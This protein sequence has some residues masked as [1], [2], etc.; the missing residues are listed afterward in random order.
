MSENLPDT[1]QNTALRDK[2]VSVVG[3]VFEGGDEDNILTLLTSLAN[4]CRNDAGLLVRPLEDEITRKDAAITDTV[5]RDKASEFTCWLLAEL[6]TVHGSPLVCE[7][8]V[9][10]QATIMRLLDSRN[11]RLFSLV[12]KDYVGI[13]LEGKEVLFDGGSVTCRSF[14]SVVR[15]DDAQLKPKDIQFTDNPQLDNLFSNITLVLGQLGDLVCHLG[16]L[17]DDIWLLV[18][19][20][21]EGGDTNLK[22]SALT[23]ISQLLDTCGLPDSVERVDYLLQCVGAMVLLPVKSVQDPCDAL[24]PAVASTSMAKQQAD[25]TCAATSEDG[26]TFEVPLAKIMMDL[27]EHI[28]HLVP[29]LQEEFLIML[30]KV[31]KPAT[32][33]EKIPE[34]LRKPLVECFCLLMDSLTAVSSQHSQASCVLEECVSHSLLVPEVSRVFL[35]RLVLAELLEALPATAATTTNSESLEPITKKGK[36]SD[37]KPATPP[38]TV[39]NISKWWKMAMQKLSTMFGSWSESPG[40]SIQEIEFVNI[41]ISNT[42]WLSVNIPPSE[43]SL[44]FLPEAW[45]VAMTDTMTT[46]ITSTE[47]TTKVVAM[48]NLLVTVAWASCI[49]ETSEVRATLLH[50]WLALATLPWMTAEVTWMDLKPVNARNLAQCAAKLHWTS[51]PSVK[52][53]SVALVALLP[54]FVAPCWRCH[55]V[56]SVISEQ[57]PQVMV[58]VAAWFPMMVHQLNE[59]NGQQLVGEVTGAVLLSSDTATVLAAAHCFRPLLCALLKLTSVKSLREAED[60]KRPYL[61]CQVCDNAAPSQCPS[62]TG[63]DT[64]LVSRFLGLLGHH[65]TAVVVAVVEALPTVVMHTTITS[66]MVSQ[67]LALLTHQD[68]AVVSVLCQQLP[69]LVCVREQ[70]PNQESKSLGMARDGEMVLSHLNGIVRES[71]CGEAASTQPVMAVLEALKHIV[72]HPLGSLTSGVLVLLLRCLFLKVRTATSFAHLAIH[73]L[74]K[75]MNLSLKDLYAR[76]RQALSQV[77][78]SAVNQGEVAAL[79][80]HVAE[81]FKWPELSVVSKRSPLNARLG[82]FVSSQLQYLLPALVVRAAKEAKPGLLQDLAGC[83]G[84]RLRDILIDHFQHILAHLVFH[85]SEEQQEAVLNF[86]ATTTEIQILDIRRCSVQNQVNE[87]VLGLHDHRKSVLREFHHMKAIDATTSFTSSVSSRASSSRSLKRKSTSESSHVPQQDEICE[88]LAPRLLGILGFLDNKLLSSSTMF[89]LDECTLEGLVEEVVIVVMPLIQKRPEQMEPVLTHVLVEMP[90]VKPLLGNLPLLPAV[91]ALAGI[92]KSIMESQPKVEGGSSEEVLQHLSGILKGLSHESIDVRLSA[93][94]RLRHA[95]HRNQTAVH[96]LTT[97]SDNVHPTVSEL[98]SALLDQCREVDED[99]QVLVAEC[100]GLLGAIDPSRLYSYSNIKEEL[101]EIHLNIESESF[102]VQLITELG[103]A[104]LA[105]TDASAQ[106]CASYALQEVTRLYGIRESG[107]EETT[108]VGSKAWEQLR[109]HLQE[110][111]HPLLTSKYTLSTGSGRPTPALSSPIFGSPHATSFQQ[112]LTSWECSLIDMLKSERATQVFNVCKPILRRDITTAM[113]MLPSMLV[114]V[115]CEAPQHHPHVLDEVLAVINHVQEKDDE[116]NKKEDSGA[117]ASSEFKQLAVQTVFSALDYISKWTQKQRQAESVGKK[118]RGAFVPSKELKQVMSFLEKIPADILAQTSYKMQSYSRALLHIE[119]YLKDNSDQLKEHLHFLQC[120]YVSLDEP[121]GVA[122]VAAIRREDPSLEEQVIQHEAT[123]RLQDA[124]GC[125]ERLCVTQGT[126][127]VYKGL[128][129]CYISVDQ[130]HSVLNITQGL[131]STRPELESSLN[132]YRVEAAWRLGKWDALE[133]FLKATTE[134]PSWGVGVGQVLRAVRA[135]DHP[136][137]QACLR[138]LRVN[139]ISVLSAASMEKWAYQR[140]YPNILRLHMLTELEEMVSGLLCFNLSATE[141]LRSSN[142]RLV[143]ASQ[144]VQGRPEL[145]GHWHQRPLDVGELVNLWDKRLRLI[146]TSHRCLEPILSFRRTLFALSSEWLQETNPTQSTSLKTELERTWLHSAKVARKSGHTQQG[147]WALLGAGFGRDVFVE[148]AKWHWVK[149]EHHQAVTTLNRGIDKFY[150]AADTIKGDNSER[151]QEERLACGRAKLLLAKYTEE[152]ATLDGNAIKQ[153]YRDAC[154]MN[155]Q[156]EDGHFHLAMYYDRILNSLEKKEKPVEWIHHIILSFGKSLQHGCCHIYQSMPRMLGLWLEFGTRVSELEIREGRSAA[157][158]RNSSLELLQEKL[159]TLN[160]AIGSMVDR[161]PHY[162]FLTALPQL[163]SRICHSHN[164]VFKQLCKIIAT[165]LSTFPQQA[166]WHMVAVSKSSYH[167]RVARCSEIFEAAKIINPS[168]SK[169]IADATKLADKFLE[170]SNKPVEKGVPQASLNNLLRGLPRLL[171]D[172]SFSNI[173]LPLQHQMAA[174]LPSTNDDL[175]SHNP[176]P[177]TPVYLSSIEDKVEIMQSLQLP[178]KITLRGSDGKC[179]I[180]MCKPKDDLRKDCRLMEFNNFVNR[181]LLR[182]PESRKRDLHIR[183]YAVV[184]LNEECGL[185]EWI[186][187]LHGLRQILHRLYRDSGNYMPAQEL[188]QNMCKR[189]APLVTKREVYL[190]KLVPRHPPVFGTW[191][192]R[193]F[194]DP[195]AWLRARLAYCRTT[196][197]MSMVGYILGLGDRHGE[198]ILFDASCGDTVHV[199]FNC[200]FN[201]GETFD[202]PERVPFRLTHNMVA[203]MGPTGHEGIYRKACEVTMRVMREEREALMSVLRPFIHDPLVEWSRGN[204]SARTTGEIN[205]EKA[206]M[207]VTNIEHRLSGQIR[208]KGRGLNQP[209]SVEGQVNSLIEEATS[210]DNLCQMY[211]GWA[212]YM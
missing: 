7:A 161:L 180:M 63:V 22:M 177:R 4:V 193:T 87:L 84:Y 184:P 174:T 165:M 162:M 137:Y 72:R 48:L 52:S 202:Y 10:L 187:N 56:R 186:E 20:C 143:H 176:F 35:R 119:T 65:D 67:Y 194:P 98:F 40:P 206:Q 195:Q 121:D 86:I 192:L 25:S 158:T 75:T 201:K 76:H 71:E 106:T 9:N 169:F 54:E 164:D 66:P 128:L 41:I 70:H 38:V 112:W 33:M 27:Q 78:S 93:L 156:W 189:D 118:L 108:A 152:A 178:K 36:F 47:D 51:D 102:I 133:T 26:R 42:E 136:A 6:I 97:A 39:I 142:S 170:L 30:F 100:L 168:L 12:M 53:K 49:V 117:A 125:Y 61:H 155:R 129:E 15:S 77:L 182:D 150:P 211:I 31:F 1:S 44:Q 188:K 208:S 91:D 148:R 81:V 45:L 34:L 139:H 111:I 159:A 14:P 146:Q 11:P 28:P 83:L 196:A 123:G 19:N 185:I 58:E 154:E 57:Q 101:N 95:L 110:I 203:A 205:N 212:A 120:I 199:D 88:Y 115:L 141:A 135:R 3:P 145:E 105:A 60:N 24:A 13:G 17:Q 104:F 166:M 126:E 167:M 140:A 209:L 74:A 89:N 179:Y 16:S 181:L 122:G 198:N 5:G 94:G 149:G 96:H 18:T 183:S 55:V 171:A 116:G 92:N 207:H 151:S 62:A 68:K 153:Y 109:Y 80:S 190:N 157:S 64:T 197:V 99:V 8:N 79:L 147:E 131:L 107:S 43:V 29:F 204:K 138:T 172:S 200:L 160:G 32:L 59:V 69:A 163:I 130:P 73:S 50:S 132:K 113:Y 114:C 210:I 85:H 46:V 37:Q 144:Q 2:F 127:E 191:F 124:L 23:A 134:Q 82:A 103:R 21:L 90:S 175:K 173:I